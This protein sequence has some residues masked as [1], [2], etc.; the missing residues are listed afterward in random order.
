M[1]ID[2]TILVTGGAGFIGSHLV[3][4]LLDASN[5]VVCL[6]KLT[7]AALDPKIRSDNFQLVVG[8]ICD[9]NIVQRVLEEFKPDLVAHL[10]A[11]THVDRSIDSPHAFTVSNVLGTQVLLDASLEYWRRLAARRQNSFRFLFL[12]TDEVYGS[13]ECGA[14]SEEGRIAPSSPYAAS[15]AAADHFVQAY[16]AT[17][18]LPTVTLRTTNNYG[19]RQFPEKLIPLMLQNAL[20]A[21]E[22]PI[23]GQGQQRRCWLHVEDHI[24]GIIAALEKADPG[25]VYNLG[26]SDE[27][28]NLE[29]VH[30]LCEVTKRLA[31]GVTDCASLVAYVADRPGHDFRYCVDDAKARAELAWTPKI[32]FEVGLEQTLRWYLE[33]QEWVAAICQKSHFEGDRLGVR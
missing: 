30:R 26:A 15:K 12:S 22:L 19:P 3:N 13:V 8:D 4:K 2:Q 20:N 10:A 16:H 7:Y 21:K 1:L 33:N 31:S 6:D 11:E 32:P 28:T 9:A 14:V 5:R 27:L 18:Q 17:F 29:V 25:S 23:Y 24:T